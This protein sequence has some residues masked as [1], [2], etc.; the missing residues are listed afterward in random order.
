MLHWAAGGVGGFVDV[1]HRAQGPTC[2]RCTERST[3]V[4]AG[5]SEQGPGVP[6]PV[7]GINGGMAGWMQG[8]MSCPDLGLEDFVPKSREWEDQGGCMTLK[9]F[10]EANVSC[11]IIQPSLPQQGYVIRLALET[12]PLNA[13]RS[14]A[15]GEEEDGCRREVLLEGQGF[16]K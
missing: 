10:P 15:G 3:Q 6:A 11:Q 16:K 14:H 12:V 4:A 13:S 1:E 5:Q 8:A 9:T 2:G 7:C